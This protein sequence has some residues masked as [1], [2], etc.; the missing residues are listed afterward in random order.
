ME[1]LTKMLDE[2]IE[3]IKEMFKELNVDVDQKA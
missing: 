2:N 1:E 3:A